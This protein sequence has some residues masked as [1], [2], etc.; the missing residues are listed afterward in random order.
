VSYTLSTQGNEI[1]FG[2][3]ARDYPDFLRD[4]SRRTGQAESISFP[5]DEQELRAHLAAARARKLP[6]TIQAARTGITGGAVPAGGHVINLSRMNRF[7]GMGYDRDTGCF[8]LRVQP[9]VLLSEIREAL[10]GGDFG[11]ADR[12][13]ESIKTLER[14]RAQGAFFFPPDP[15]ETS[16]AIGGMTACNASGARSFRYGPMRRYVDRLRLVLADG[17][18]VVVTRGALR[19]AG[20]SFCLKTVGGR[21]IAGELP[22]YRMPDVKNAAG[23]YAEDDMDL[24]DLFI[25]SEGTLGVAT[26]IDLR[27]IPAPAVVWGVAAFLPSEAAALDFVQRLR[28][29]NGGAGTPGPAAIEFFDSRA[30][31]M[32]RRQKRANPA[33][34]SLPDLAAAWDTAVYV[35]YHGD[36]SDRVEAAVMDMSEL[37]A[38]CGGSEDATWLASE[39][40]ELERLKDFRHAVPEAVNLL[41]DERRKAEPGLTKLGTDLAVPDSKLAA[42]MELYHR[43][44]AAA[45]LDYVVFGHIGNNHVHVNIIPGSL[46]QYNV[47]RQLYVEWAQAVVAMGGTV[48]AEHG[49]GKLKTDLLRVMYGEQG[50]NQMRRLKELF[51]PAWTLNRGN[52]FSTSNDNPE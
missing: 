6:V 43:G 17:D 37:L 44:L 23:Y 45:G 7:L 26:E 52:L 27:L 24:I 39:E 32:L 12:S 41:I 31:D 14:L 19:A 16:A 5:R 9:G 28:E 22:S 4:E 50:I 18:A 15:T 11:A 34:A 2:D 1:S 21:E 33:F 29:A 47:G 30:L 42:M 48:S 51:D 3:I 36:D 25:G 8:L 38:D 10:A 40:R 49:I 46:D 35:E 20:R 13:A